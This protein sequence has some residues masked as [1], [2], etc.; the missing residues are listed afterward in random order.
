[1]ISGEDITNLNGLNVITA[2]EGELLIEDNS[3]L[4]DLT[5]LENLTTIGWNLRIGSS[6]QNYQALTSLSGLD[7]LILVDGFV[8][9]HHNDNLTS[10]FASNSLTSVDGLFITDNAILTELTGLYGIYGEIGNL[11]ISNNASL[12]S[13]A[14]L[15]NITFVGYIAGI[16]NNNALLNIENLE[17]LYST[18]WLYIIN[19]PALTSLSGLDNLTFAYALNISENDAL[20]SLS[21]LENVAIESL[22]ILSIFDNT[23]LSDCDI[24]NICDYIVKPNAM[25]N[26]YDNA[27]GCN[28]QQ[29]VEE[30]CLTNTKDISANK[31]NIIISPNPASKTIT[32]LNSS[33]AK[34]TEV[35]I[36]NQT[37]QIVLQKK[38]P[39]NTIDISTLQAG[40][41]FVE[42]ITEQGNV[43]KKL[44]VE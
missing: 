28:S 21:G 39:I 22:W 6:S 36:F 30:A 24:Q 38:A 11:E 12:L 8:M 9:I 35:T 18:E 3:S 20:T 2:I 17:N 32:I 26:I 42:V 27:T 15:D 41:Y 43:R 19:N 7:N 10:L 33:K 37:G 1:M 44:I 13:L 34:I 29:E 23:V 5:G 25:I 16:R 14:G 4:E 31:N 40:L